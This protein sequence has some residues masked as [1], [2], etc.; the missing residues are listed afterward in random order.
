MGDA[1]VF[2]RTGSYNFCEK[3]ATSKS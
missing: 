1:G 3:A 2:W